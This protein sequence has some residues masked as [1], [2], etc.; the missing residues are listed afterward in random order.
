MDYF[1][2]MKIP[3]PIKSLIDPTR[4][5]EQHSGQGQSDIAG[6]KHDKAN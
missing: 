6:K 4:Q 1:R 2:G 3:L 5:L